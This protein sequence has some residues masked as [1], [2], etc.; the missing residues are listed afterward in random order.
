[1]RLRRAVVGLVMGAVGV[2][3]A[4]C[5]GATCPSVQGSWKVTEHCA[6]AQ[7]GQ[8]YT[9]NQN[10]CTLT[11]AAS[12]ITFSGSVGVDNSFSMIGT[13]GSATMTCNGS[14]SGAVITQTCNQAGEPPC[15]MS[16]AK[17]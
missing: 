1:M 10:G 4:G 14:V 15:A 17:Q 6:S 7:V 5:G 12:G 11:V 9:M 3:A 2:V 16:L 8:T 13:V